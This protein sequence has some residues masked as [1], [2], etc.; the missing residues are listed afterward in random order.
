MQSSLL[1]TEHFLHLKKKLISIC[2]SSHALCP[3]DPQPLVYLLSLRIYLSRTFHIRGFWRRSLRGRDRWLTLEL[4]R[5]NCRLLTPPLSLECA[6]SLVF[7]HWSPFAS[8]EVLLRR[9][10]GLVPLTREQHQAMAGFS[11]LLGPW[12]V[13]STCLPRRR[14]TGTVPRY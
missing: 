5:G 12:N 14:Y 8:S 3:P 6:F 1:I 4:H 13:H 7:P 9:T 10:S 2:I 11:P